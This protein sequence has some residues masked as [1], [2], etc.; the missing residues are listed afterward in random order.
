MKVSLHL[1]TT[2][3]VNGRYYKAGLTIEDEVNSDDIGDFDNFKAVAHAKVDDL[4]DAM[5]PILMDKLTNLVDAVGAMKF[6]KGRRDR[7]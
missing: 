6:T 2:V 3:E 4:E 7:G 5:Q 1:G